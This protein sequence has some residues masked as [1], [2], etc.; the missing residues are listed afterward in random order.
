MYNAQDSV[1]ERSENVSILEFRAEDSLLTGCQ[2]GQC[3]G[4][5]CEEKLGYRLQT[6]SAQALATQRSSF[7]LDSEVECGQPFL[8]STGF[9][10]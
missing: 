2:E 4:L 6:A 10:G 9:Q 7:S 1:S 3:L 5:G 8:F